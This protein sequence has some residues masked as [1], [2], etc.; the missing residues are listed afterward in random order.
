MRVALRKM[1]TA[2]DIIGGFL[3]TNSNNFQDEETEGMK[4]PLHP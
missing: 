3:A 2:G 1:K 4:T